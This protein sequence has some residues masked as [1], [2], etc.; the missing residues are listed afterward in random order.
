MI[1]LGIETSCDETSAAVYDSCSGIKS[2]VIS[3]QI[4]IHSRYGGVVPEIASRNHA[5]KIETVFYEAIEKASISVSDIDA[6]GVTR[7]PGLI[8]A[9]F[10]GVSFAK[11]LSYALKIPL[12][13]V[14]HLSA[15]IVSAELTHPE[16]VPPYTGLIISG[17]H[18]HIYQVD[19]SYN[20]RLFSYTVDDAAGEAFDKV[21][22]M[23]GLAY[24]GGPAIENLS[25][26][27]NP[28]AVKF[29]VAM[30]AQSNMSFSGLKTAVMNCLNQGYFTKADIA[31]SFQSTLV[32]TL[33]NKSQIALKHFNSDKLVISGGVACNGYLRDKF[34]EYFK[35]SCD[36][37]FPSKYLCTDNG[38][39]IAYAAYKFM[40]LRKFLDIKGTA[41]DNE[42]SINTII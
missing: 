34:H 28:D 41:R 40:H 15:H 4:D 8:G 14:N 27:G 29:P 32:Q 33:I 42:S 5:L 11:G 36:I 3:S 38:D 39:M 9:L 20:F 18:S 25:T 35:D 26:K 23:M 2:S 19:K 1:F 6:V 10:V 24:P 31:A 7:A 17:G 21:A 12:I 37:Y 30:K 22:K 13:P 16:L